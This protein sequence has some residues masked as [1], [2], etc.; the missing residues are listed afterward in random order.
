[1]LRGLLELVPELVAAGAAATDLV[2]VLA[3]DEE[4]AAALSPLLVALRQEAGETV[5]APAE[6]PQ[7]A[8]DIREVIQ[9]KRQARAN[10]T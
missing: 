2:E 3:G 7:V 4:K 8:A 5:R 10:S 1:M 6:I 9:G